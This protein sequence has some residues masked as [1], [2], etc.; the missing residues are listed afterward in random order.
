M[1]SEWVGVVGALG[2]AGIGG[3]VT[4]ASLIVKARQDEAAEKRRSER[5][6]RLRAEDRARELHI[7]NLE[8]RRSLYARLLRSADK[9]NLQA[10]LVLSRTAANDDQQE[11][12]LRE[13]LASLEVFKND[14]AATEVAA[15]DRTVLEA[16]TELGDQVGAII[17]GIWLLGI[18]DQDD[19]VEFGERL[20]KINVELFPKLRA[21]IRRDLFEDDA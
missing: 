10:V 7:Q 3:V 14:A 21:A 4:V 15:V 20:R 19:Q 9:V 5:E 16:A 12:L 13:A 8:D 6:D 2:G 1:A 17:Q 11:R 18:H